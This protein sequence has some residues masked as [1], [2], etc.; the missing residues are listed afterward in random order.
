MMNMSNRQAIL[1]ADS[2][3]NRAW[4][5]PGIFQAI[6]APGTDYRQD[7]LGLSEIVAKFEERKKPYTDV[8]REMVFEH[9]RQVSCNGGQVNLFAPSYMYHELNLST[10]GVS[11]PYPDQEKTLY[12]RFIRGGDGERCT[13][14]ID[15]EKSGS[16]QGSLA[17]VQM[18]A[19]I[20]DQASWAMSR[21]TKEEF[22]ACFC[23]SPLLAESLRRLSSGDTFLH[24][25]PPIPLE[26][27]I[28]DP[29]QDDV[30]QD[31]EEVINIQQSLLIEVWD[32]DFMGM[33]FL[34]E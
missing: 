21:I 22:I 18:D 5:V 16:I 10:M 11:D 23:G 32:S 31:L 29:Q 24:R 8:T 25:A 12:V 15:V 27:T 19:L 7:R 30:F 13:Q 9:E 1:V 34:G 33:K 4:V 28:M 26:V 17:E 14:A 6:L 20:K 3:F 2:L